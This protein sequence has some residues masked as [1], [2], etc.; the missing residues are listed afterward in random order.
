M[1]AALDSTPAA[2]GFRMPGE[3]ER[4]DGCWMAWPER[5]DN[6]RLGAGPAQAAFAAVAEALAPAEPVTVAASP[7][8]LRRARELLPDSVRVVELATDDA[9]MRDIGPTYV[10]DGRGGRRGVDWEFNA[11]GGLEGGLYAPWDRDDAAAARILEIE[12]TERYRAPLVLEG[13]SIHVDGEGTVLTTE[14]CLLNRNRNPALSRAQV[15]S[16]LRAY[17]GAE[18]VVW[19]GRGVHEDETDGHVDNLACFARPGLVLL[20]WTDDESDPQQAISADARRRLETATDARGRHFE[21]VL[22]P[23]PGPLTAT[24]EEA[25]GVEAVEGTTPRRPGDRLAAS[26]VNFYPANGRLVM[27]LLDER[28]DE[29]AAA[30]LRRAFP[31]REVVGV[32]AR[33]ILLGGGNVHCI[34]QQVPAG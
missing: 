25:A 21:V 24:A 1:A 3:F 16:H 29:E 13:G 9:W 22:L 7:A 2:D 5:P 19:L 18:K 31:D 14:E 12:A 27:P 34:V 30:T 11:W 28:H 23:S 32:P 6:W 33:E 15:E 4:H 26:Y 8:Q 17:L 20:T 10:V